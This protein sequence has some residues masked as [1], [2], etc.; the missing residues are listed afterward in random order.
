MSTRV[1]DLLL[2]TN[3]G[4]DIDKIHTFF[5]QE[6]AREIKGIELSAHTRPPDKPYSQFA[7]SG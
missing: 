3:Q 1:A 7:T 6:T 4:W 5:N 2:S